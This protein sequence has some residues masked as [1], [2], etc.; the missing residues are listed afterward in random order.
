MNQIE[1]TVNSYIP[2]HNTNVVKHDSKHNLCHL[3]L[4]IKM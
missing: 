3:N 4:T 2:R 1:L